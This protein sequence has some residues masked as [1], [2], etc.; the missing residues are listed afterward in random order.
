M[1]KIKLFPMFIP[2]RNYLM[3]NH[4]MELI[5]DILFGKY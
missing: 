4:G 2:N 1:D 3:F 5:L